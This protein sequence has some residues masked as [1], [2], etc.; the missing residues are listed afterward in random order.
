[1]DIDIEQ[2]PGQIGTAILDI[3]DGKIIKVLEL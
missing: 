3:R 1:M 2:V